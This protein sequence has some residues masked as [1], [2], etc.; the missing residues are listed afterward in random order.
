VVVLFFGHIVPALVLRY[1]EPVLVDLDNEREFGQ[2]VV[3]YPPATYTLPPCGFT[4]VPI[5]FFKAVLK[6]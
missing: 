4:Q 2:V 6:H 5:H 3:V 1:I